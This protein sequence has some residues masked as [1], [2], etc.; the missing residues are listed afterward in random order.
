MLSHYS[1]TL[2]APLAHLRPKILSPNLFLLCLRPSVEILSDSGH[3]DVSE[4]AVEG[5]LEPTEEEA[6]AAAAPPPFEPFSLT[7]CSSITPLVVLLPSPARER[8]SHI[9]GGE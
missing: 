7:S 1:F 5:E 3:T 8:A 6:A 2:V 4:L 9:R